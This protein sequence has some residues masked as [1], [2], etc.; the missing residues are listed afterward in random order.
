ML[1]TVRSNESEFLDNNSISTGDLFKNLAELATIN[2]LLGGHRASVMGMAE[3]IRSNPS[4]KNILDVGFGGGDS[5]LHLSKFAQERNLS[6]MFHGVDLKPD[7]LKYAE[8]ILF[9]LKNK[10]LICKDY[11]DLSPEMLEQMDVIHCGLFLHH[12][13]DEEIIHLFQMARFHKCI[14]LIND[15]HRHW[16][17]YQSIRLLTGLFSGSWLVKNDAPISVKRGFR[18][19]ELIALL[20]AAGF[21][22]YTVKWTWAFRYIVIAKR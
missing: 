2:K 1:Y 20:K 6:L 22:D 15:L 12:L 16:F 10:S 3:I 18:K 17:A 5:I 19:K 14:L 8:A 4:V 7:C 21:S 9:S 11:R 13:D